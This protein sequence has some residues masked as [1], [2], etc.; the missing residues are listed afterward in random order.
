MHENGG[1]R[2]LCKRDCTA[3]KRTNFPGSERR[4]RVLWLSTPF[5]LPCQSMK[6]RNRIIG[7]MKMPFMRD[8]VWGNTN[9]QEEAKDKTKTD[10]SMGPQLLKK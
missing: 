7:E 5:M 10:V 4:Q 1:L 3:M 6:R 9:R 8:L 2:G